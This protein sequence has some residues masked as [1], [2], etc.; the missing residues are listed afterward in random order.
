MIHPDDLAAFKERDTEY[1]LKKDHVFEF[2]LINRRNELRWLR[3]FSR[4]VWNEK[5]ERV[6]ELYG[7][8]QDITD[9]KL[10]QIALQET[11]QLLSSATDAMSANIAI[12]DR[13]GSTLA[14]R[15]DMTISAQICG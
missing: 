5:E 14:L 10:A 8:I 1:L 11:Q 13:D 9:Q 7:A 2:R 12:L 4:P 6:T 3:E 15:P